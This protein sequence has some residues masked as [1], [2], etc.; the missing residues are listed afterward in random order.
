MLATDPRDIYDGSAQIDQ[1]FTS[2]PAPR[3]RAPCH[4][5]ASVL[6][7]ELAYDVLDHGERFATVLLALDQ[8][9]IFL[10]RGWRLYTSPSPRD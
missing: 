3:L 4:D 5:P 9:N 8:P 7:H 1:R 6:Q 10:S 2:P